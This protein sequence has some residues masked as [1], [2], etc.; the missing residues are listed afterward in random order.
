[1]FHEI[2]HGRKKF[3]DTI[4]VF[5]RRSVRDCIDRRPRQPQTEYE[6]EAA[7]SRSMPGRFRLHASAFVRRSFCHYVL[8]VGKMIQFRGRIYFGPWRRFGR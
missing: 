6:R 2:F 4:Y 5:E 8:I 1:M 3:H 7:A